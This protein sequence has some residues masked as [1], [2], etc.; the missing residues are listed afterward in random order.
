MVSVVILLVLGSVT[1][2][3]GKPAL[4]EVGMAAS[5]A[6]PHL[7]AKQ[8]SHIQ[9]QLSPHTPHSFLLCFPHFM[10]FTFLVGRSRT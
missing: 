2:S 1:S 7:P 9:L 10:H 5:A 6:K 4:L 8:Q 3:Q